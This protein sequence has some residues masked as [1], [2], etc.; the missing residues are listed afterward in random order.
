MRV[1]GA[2]DVPLSLHPGWLRVLRQGLGHTPFGVE[3]RDG[4]VLRGYLPLALVDS[5]LFGRFLVALPYVNYGGPVADNENTARLLLD[6]AV[7]L[8]DVCDV[9]YL[10]V[11]ATRPL[12]H[13]T[14]SD[15]LTSKVHM[16]LTLPGDGEQ[17]WKRIDGKVRNQVRKAQAANFTV[18]WG[19][20]ERLDEFYRVFAHNMRDL[21][22]PVYAKR[23]FRAILSS[24][25]DRAEFCVVRHGRETA[26]AALLLHGWGVTEVPSASSLRSFNHTNANMLMYWHLLL[27]AIERRQRA[28]DFGRSTKDGSVYR[29]KKQWGAVPLPAEWQYYLRR[30]DIREMRPENP[31]YDQ[32]KA[33]WKRLP[34]PLA[35]WLGPRIVKGI[36]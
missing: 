33:A 12:N 32:L 16:R 36:P 11:R 17:L 7:Q 22:T 28:F 2:E 25:A 18:S 21:G 29:F 23:F 20:L 27:R 30:G 8:A 5:W 10:E 9:K 1:N 34:V 3:V 19:G 31:R 35:N 15:R 13:P 6:Q 14:L 26:A 4:S 24:F